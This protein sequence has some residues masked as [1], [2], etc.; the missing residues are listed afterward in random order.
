VEIQALLILVQKEVFFPFHVEDMN[1]GS[2]N[3]MYSGE[4]KIWFCFNS[5][6][7]DAVV[8]YLG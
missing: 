7:H 2:I 3:R 5:K 6:I 1:L 4:P 8:K